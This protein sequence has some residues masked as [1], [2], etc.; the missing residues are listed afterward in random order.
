MHVIAMMHGHGD[1]MMGGSMSGVM[2]GWMLLWALLALALIV[3]AV[4]ATVWLVKHLSGSGSGSGSREILER[5]YADGEIDRDE[6]LQ[7]R[8]DLTRRS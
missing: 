8:G 4:V 2:G 6:Y 5:R 1:D 7:R 3:L